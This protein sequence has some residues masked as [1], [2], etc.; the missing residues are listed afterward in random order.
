MTARRDEHLG[1]T[2]GGGQI[3]AVLGSVGRVQGSLQRRKVIRL[4]LLDVLRQIRHQRLEGRDELWI[5]GLHVL[6]NL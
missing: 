4:F 5:R 2:E 3:L 1:A 6:E